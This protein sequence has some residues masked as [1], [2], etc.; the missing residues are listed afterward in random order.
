VDRLGW[1]RGFEGETR[2]FSHDGVGVGGSAGQW[3]YRTA[4]S[5]LTT[6]P[7]TVRD[8]YGGH[9]GKQ[10]QLDEFCKAY[11]VA[12]TKIEA[13]TKGL[14]GSLANASAWFIKLVYCGGKRDL[15]KTIEAVVARDGSSRVEDKGFT[16]EYC[17]QASEFLNRRGFRAR[18]TVEGAES[19]RCLA[20]ETQ[21]SRP[22]VI[23][24]WTGHFFVSIHHCI[25]RL[26]RL[27]LAGL[28]SFTENDLSNL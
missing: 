28:C 9:W 23:V 12:K 5:I 10:E 26:R 22:A 7:V 2:L 6:R 19:I 15:M 27:K 16:G 3:R 4:V 24:T 8:N 13:S 25:R 17:R 1:T 18:R 20:T 21:R 14:L 11:A